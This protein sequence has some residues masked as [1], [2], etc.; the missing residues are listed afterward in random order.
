VSDDDY[1]PGIEFHDDAVAEAR[2]LVEE[3][4]RDSVTFE[5]PACHYMIQIVPTITEIKVS[6]SLLRVK[7][8]EVNVP[9]HC[10]QFRRVTQDG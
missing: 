10:E 2:R 4:E 1:N 6:A 7:F 9:H 3:R 8:L 5:C